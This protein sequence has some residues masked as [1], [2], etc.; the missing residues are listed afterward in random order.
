VISATDTT[1]QTFADLLD[2]P[3]NPYVRDPVGWVSDRLGEFL[4]SK[5]R[6]ILE[7]VVRHRYVAVKSAHDTGKARPLDATLPTPAGW[8]TM[9][10]IQV[11]EC[12]LDEQ[13]QPA[14]VVSKSPVWEQACFRVV[15]DDGVL[16]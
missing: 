14:R 6:E 9:G 5:Q 10:D 12:V 2:P 3:E 16:Q 8:R 1:W 13:G 7:A 4:W 15:F 11:G